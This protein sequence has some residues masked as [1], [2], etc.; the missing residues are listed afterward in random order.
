M[1]PRKPN[2][3]EA[4]QHS[5]RA[6]QERRA[7]EEASGSA[8]PSDAP[9]E[10]SAAAGPFAADGSAPAAP[11]VGATRG[12][13]VL[14]TAPPRAPGMNPRLPLILG[15]VLVAM[16]V[17]FLI[18][19]ELGQSD[20]VQA[21][22]DVEVPVVTDPAVEGST[23]VPADPRNTQ[24]SAAQDPPPA[25]P[26]SLTADDRAFVDKR[27]NW[28]VI[29][30]SYENNAKGGELA[31]ATYLYLCEQGLPA[32][33]PITQGGHLTI[34]VGAEPTRNAAIEG[35]RAQLQRLKGPPPQ[36][37]SAPFADAYFANIEDLLDP[38][39]RR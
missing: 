7:G 28:T 12:D 31:N 29:A 13:E 8:A 9:S 30:I 32:V 6:D 18:G 3:L 21:G 27:N 25:P 19:R 10:E 39:L 26:K 24:D 35:V 37:E 23:T 1:S 4:F 34:C 15:A 33:K 2:M 38:A 17:T 5:A 14:G 22:P 11:S 16:V 20:E 36:N